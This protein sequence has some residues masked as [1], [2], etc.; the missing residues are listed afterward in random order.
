M[1]AND[2]VSITSN[3]TQQLRLA[4]QSD[5]YGDIC[6]STNTIAKM[7]YTTSL[8][9][10]INGALF[11]TAFG[12]RALANANGTRNSAFGNGALVANNGGQYNTSV[13]YAS[14]NT[15]SSASY[16]TVV[17]D[18]ALYTAN[19]NDN[20]AI[21]F[22]ALCNNTAAEQTALGSWALYSHTSGLLNVAIGFKSLYTDTIGYRNIGIGHSTLYSSTASYENVAIGAESLY[23]TKAGSRNV[24]IGYQTLKVLQAGTDNMAIGSVAM[25][26]CVSGIRNVAIGTTSLYNTNN[27]Y[28][29][30]I[31]YQAGYN[32]YGTR[33][34]AIGTN[35][36]IG[37]DGGAGFPALWGQY[38]VAIGDTTM[39]QTN[40]N[41]NTG[42]GGLSMTSNTT[43]IGNTAIGYGSAAAVTGSYS[44]FIG[45]LAGK[46]EKNGN[47]LYIANSAVTNPL[48][49]GEFDNSFIRFNATNVSITGSLSAGEGN[50][51]GGQVV[52][53]YQN[54]K[55]IRFPNTDAQDCGVIDYAGFD[56]NALSIVGKGNS[57]SNRLIRL[58]DKV[59]INVAPNASYSLYVDGAMRMDNQTTAAP[60]TVGSPPNFTDFYGQDNIALTE[61]NAWW[62]VNFGG[63]NYVMPLYSV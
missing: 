49:Y 48:I 8:M 28:N 6:V 43:G 62:L 35:A 5:S 18:S 58:Y 56:S 32:V 26:N 24:G 63:S 19:S 45:Y 55:K 25:L 44:V 2:T 23:T 47:R 37:W 22:A 1:N 27:S 15:N 29:I 46:Y 42:V 10:Y 21:G 3:S 41:Y 59:G 40:A 53:A 30:G 54:A 60:G 12:Y 36:M 16:N 51:A 7:S 33:N 50:L 4:W 11:N 61:P 31:G 17:G 57:T 52:L 14:M 9:F 38:N 34:V 39:Q 13:G 20:T